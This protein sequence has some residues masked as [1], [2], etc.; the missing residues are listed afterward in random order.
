MEKVK[1]LDQRV[2]NLEKRFEKRYGSPFYVRERKCF[3]V[4]EQEFFIVSRLLCF[5]AIV[6]EHAFSETEAKKNVFEDGDLFYI[7][8]LTEEEMFNEMIKEIEDI[9]II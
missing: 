1:M 4:S 6:I 2:Q 8:E 9:D 3:T 7:D 5:N